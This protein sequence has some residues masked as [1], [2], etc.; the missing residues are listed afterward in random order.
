MSALTDQILAL[1]QKGAFSEAFDACLQYVEECKK[2]FS[3]ALS[4]NSATAYAG[5]VILLSQLCG[6]EKKPWKA[7]PS[8]DGA[9]GCLR[10]MEDYVQSREIVAETF[11]SFASAYEYAGFL[12]EAYACYKKALDRGLDVNFLKDAAYSAF[13]LSLR[14]FGKIEE[15]AKESAL[16]IFTEEETQLLQEEAEKHFSELLL[17][18]PVEKSEEYLKLRYQVEKAVDEAL[19]ESKDMETPYFIR[20]WA[21][22]KKILLEQYGIDWKTPAECNPNVRFQ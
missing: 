13:I 11:Q 16:S 9:N 8:L 14:V 19:S 12:P 1:Y 15:S 5:S 2:E 3:L 22:K 10:F 18:D 17:V 6:A 21:C 7:I 20:Y 4:V